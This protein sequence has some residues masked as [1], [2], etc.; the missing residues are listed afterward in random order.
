MSD[1]VDGVEREGE[2]D[3]GFYSDFCS[4]G[5]RSKGRDHGGNVEMPSEEG[6]GKVR[7]AEDVDPLQVS[8]LDNKTAPF[9]GVIN[10][11]EKCRKGIGRHLQIKQ[12]Q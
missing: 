4:Y 1:S 6:R 8:L 7:S 10:S 9:K 12:R 3:K 11:R 2:C 5:E